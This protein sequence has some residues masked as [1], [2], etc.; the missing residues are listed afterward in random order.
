MTD[1]YDDNDP[2]AFVKALPSDVPNHVSLALLTEVAETNDMFADFQDE[3]IAQVVEVFSILNMAPGD[4]LITKGEYATFC[5]IILRGTFTAIVTP[6][7]SVPL[8]PGD[9]VGE[10]SLFEGG[11]RNADI[12]SGTDCILAVIT[13]AD[14]DALA[15]NERYSILARKLTQLFAVA[16]IKKLRDM[17]KSQPP[18]SAAA[19]AATDNTESEQS[20]PTPAHTTATTTPAGRKA[21]AKK[22][23]VKKPLM[24]ETLY[25]QKMV[26]GT[27]N[28]AAPHPSTASSSS[29]SSSSIGS[30]VTSSSSSVASPADLPSFPQPKNL[31]EAQSRIEELRQRIIRTEHS[32]R[33]QQ[34]MFD[35]TNKQ[36]R[37]ITEAYNLAEENVARL[38]SE[39]TQLNQTCKEWKDR[40]TN[41]AKTLQ[42]LTADADRERSKHQHEMNKVTTD[43]SNMERKLQEEIDSLKTSLEQM[44]SVCDQLDHNFSRTKSELDSVL[45]SRATEVAQLKRDVSDLTSE[46]DRLLKECASLRSRSETIESE[47]RASHKA[48]TAQKATLSSVQLRLNETEQQLETARAWK[49]NWVDAQ[50]QLEQERKTF[51]IKHEEWIRTSKELEKEIRQYKTILKTFTITIYA[52]EWKLRRMLCTLHKRV[53]ELLLATLEEHYNTATGKEIDQSNPNLFGAGIGGANQSALVLASSSPSSP[54]ILAPSFKSV[55]K[56]KKAYLDS[57]SR[58]G[59]ARLHDVVSSLDEEVTKLRGPFEEVRERCLHWRA[60]SESFFQRNIDLASKLMA[61]EKSLGDVNAD[62]EVLSNQ[63]RELDR[64]QTLTTSAS[65]PT[66]VSHR[67]SWDGRRL[68]HGR[69]S[70]HSVS[71]AEL[72]LLGARA[73]VLRVHIQ[74]LESHYLQLQMAIHHAAGSGSGIA[75]CA[76]SAPL[77]SSSLT[78]S[79]YGLNTINLTN[80]QQESKESQQST[81]T[82]NR[83]SG[84]SIS[85]QGFDPTLVPPVPFPHPQSFSIHHP[86]LPP[87]THGPSGAVSPRKTATSSYASPRAPSRTLNNGSSHGFPYSPNAASGSQTARTRHNTSIQFGAGAALTSQQ[88]QPQRHSAPQPVQQPRQEMMSLHALREARATAANSNANANGAPTTT[89]MNLPAVPGVASPSSYRPS[90]SST[91]SPVVSPRSPSQSITTLSKPPRTTLSFGTRS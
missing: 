48:S 56:R 76:P 60:T 80:G 31:S 14:L 57:L 22:A 53:S 79:P 3:D 81:Y 5:G 23:D 2:S 63:V 55:R 9:M 87:P 16:S 8:R 46:R 36:L 85:G 84:D 67:S 52:K 90:L 83:R 58:G 15:A 28:T 30:N 24:A 61:L 39:V 51:R 33:N 78:A 35:R 71:K 1:Y 26:K 19:P 91:S 45:I 62:R 34:V 59:S 11:E 50:N 69:Q 21:R 64:L 77:N 70:S 40:S 13:F 54:S 32:R 12:V 86:Q 18:P 49:T 37:T 7:L 75:G 6:T 20:T 4:K 74:Q 17:L 47:L 29:S 10:M 73:T 72:D 89:L 25:K 68:E 27:S 42:E 65:P 66:S 38:N 82:S 88:P 43:A 41:L 44:T